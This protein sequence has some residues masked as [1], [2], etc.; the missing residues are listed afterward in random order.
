MQNLETLGIGE[1]FKSLV[2]ITDTG[3][4]IIAAKKNN[5]VKPR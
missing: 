4:Y 2:F 3:F 5:T 1:L